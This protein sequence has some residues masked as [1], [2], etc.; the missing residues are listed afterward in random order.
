VKLAHSAANFMTNSAFDPASK[1]PEYKVCAV[2][3]ERGSGVSLGGLVAARPT[4]PASTAPAS[5][6][7]W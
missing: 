6:Y 3:V 1:N 5:R 2:L 4:S 7:P